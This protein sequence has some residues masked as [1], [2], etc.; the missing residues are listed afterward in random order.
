MDKVADLSPKH[1]RK[2]SATDGTKKDLNI[3]ETRV[4]RLDSG[5]NL[6]PWLSVLEIVGGL[7][8]LFCTHLKEDVH[9]RNLT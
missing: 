1:L 4:W 5:P 6:Q 2:Q 7:T 9:A 3:A 8:N